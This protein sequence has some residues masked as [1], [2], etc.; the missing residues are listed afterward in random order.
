MEITDNIPIFSSRSIATNSL[1]AGASGP[2]FGGSVAFSATSKRG[3][4]LATPDPID[5]FNT[6]CI[7]IY[8]NYVKAH[9]QSWYDFFSQ[10][11]AIEL[12][13]LML[14]T[15][16]DR[17]TSWA[18]AVFDDT[19]LDAGFGLEVQFATMGAGLDL[20]CQYSWQRTRGALV[21]SGPARRR[22]SG[23]SSQGSL[24]MLP[25]GPESRTDATLDRLTGDCDRPLNISKPQERR[26]RQMK[27]MEI[28]PIATKPLMSATTESK[29]YRLKSIHSARGS[30]T[31]LNPLWTIFWS[32]PTRILPSHM[33][34]TWKHSLLRIHPL[35]PT[36]PF[37][38]VK[39]CSRKAT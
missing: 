18:T 21:N 7:P 22:S 4:I 11:H 24:A 39:G 16:V 34:M 27:K 26:T 31:A 32:T 20:A 13:D 10:R 25:N 9:V 14:V 8:M 2:F 17:T 15:G 28:V 6:T 37:M 29:V 12:E 5:C 30:M 35:N 19:Q 33:T 23:S 3:A 36:F 38:M 1:N